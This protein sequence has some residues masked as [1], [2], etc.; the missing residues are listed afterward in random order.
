MLIMKLFILTITLF[1]LISC[2]GGC[3]KKESTMNNEFMPDSIYTCIEDPNDDI[4]ID[5]LPD[6]CTSEFALNYLKE[7]NDWDKYSLGI[8][9][10]IIEQN[11]SYAKKLINNKFDHF[12]FVDKNTMMVILY[13]KF[14]HRKL[15]FKMACGKNYGTK[16]EKA[17]SRTPEGFFLC[18]GKYDSTDWLFTD[19]NG[20]TSPIKGQFGPRFIRIN[21]PITTQIG[22]HGTCARY[23]IGRRCS[24]GCIRI[25]NEQILYLYK[26][27]KKGMPII[28]NPGEKDDIINKKE[29]VEIIR[30]ILPDSVI[31][32]PEEFFKF[33]EEYEIEKA[34]KDSIEAAIAEQIKIDSI[35]KAYFDSINRIK[36]SIKIVVNKEIGPI[37]KQLID[38]LNT[39]SLSDDSVPNEE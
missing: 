36:D 16:H 33:K 23:S 14:G 9:P 25:Q 35:N 21:A 18:G 1:F 11:L 19:D 37:Q 5:S 6:N 12:I 10:S 2:F 28:V 38:S 17:D 34:K 32:N 4:K 22:I 7:S 8:I 39:K 29:G 24:H 3:N 30:I 27:T 20:Y 26:F 15:N 13:D 31:E